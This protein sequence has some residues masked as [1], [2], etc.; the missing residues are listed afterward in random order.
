MISL[1]PQVRELEERSGFFR[2]SQNLKIAALSEGAHSAAALLGEYLTPLLGETP[3][4][5]SAGA[6]FVT[7]A[8]QGKNTPDDAG[9]TEESY[10]IEISESRVRVEAASSA[11]LA[12]A[13]QTLRQLFMTDAVL[14]CCRIADAPEHRWRGLLLDTA[15]HFF[16]VKEVCGF[17]D[18][19]ALHRLNRFHLH[20]T[21]DQ[22]WRVEI[23]RYPKLTEVGSIRP[24]TISSHYPD[25]PMR[26]DHMPHG[27]FYTQQELREIVAFAARRHVEVIPEIDMP[28]HMQSA[29]A[30]YP[31]FGNYPER[32]LSVRTYW[33]KSRHILN[34]Y[35][36]T[37]R[38][39]CNILEEAME[40]FPSRFIH[41][42]GDEVIKD[43]WFEKEEIQEYITQL[44]L[45]TTEDLQNYFLRQINDFLRSHGRRMIGWSEINQG[46]VIPGAT[47]MSWLGRAAAIEAATAGAD[48]VMA[49]KDYT[50]FDFYQADPAN[51][52]PGIG[53]D[54]SCEKAYRFKVLP[55]EL[56]AEKHAHILGGQGQLWTEYISTYPHLLYMAYPRVCA[57]AEKLWLPEGFN[58]FF[59]FR[60]RLTVRRRR[61]QALGVNAHLLP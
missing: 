22:G 17:I 40:I 27:G 42:G 5:V 16:T 3:E 37:I 20:L 33:G 14:P 7:F 2:F 35:P 54:L 50:Y 12:R 6:A 38:F 36:E 51:E 60:E 46:G 47:V 1:V 25:Q 39:A 43:E 9:F 52:P 18:L 30:A 26:F 10:T 24:Q 58:T 55:P 4:I 11:G 31:E 19:L 44:G 28:G 21:D 29:V 53:G 49:D 45:K 59:Q 13:V 56:P 32:Q 34:P 15:R 57:L 48:V 41:I 8:E 23:K 61:L